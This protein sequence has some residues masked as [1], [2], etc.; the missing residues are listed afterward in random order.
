MLNTT[1]GYHAIEDRI[2]MGHDHPDERIWI[3]RRLAIYVLGTLTKQVEETAPGAQAGAASAVRAELEHR[4]AMDEP[5]D[6]ASVASPATAG[7]Y[8]AHGRAG[9]FGAAGVQNHAHHLVARR[10]LSD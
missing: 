8:R 10:A 9:A 5:A 7:G 6:M 2:W 1:F 3:T 4:M